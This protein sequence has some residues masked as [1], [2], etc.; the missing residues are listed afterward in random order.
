[1]LEKAH[2]TMSVKLVIF[3]LL[4]IGEFVFGEISSFWFGLIVALNIPPYPRD[5]ES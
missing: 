3:F 5:I 1:M 2:S 4:S